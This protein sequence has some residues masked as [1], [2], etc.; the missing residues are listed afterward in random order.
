MEMNK[1]TGAG[2]ALLWDES[3]LWGLMAAGALRSAGIRFDLL[4]AG[5][6]RAGALADYGAIYVPGGWAGQKLACLGEAGTAGIRSFV[7]NGGTYIGICGGAGLATAD[8]L[9][10]LE[11]RRKPAGERVPSFSG[12]IRLSTNPHDIWNGIAQPVFTAAWPSQLQIENREIKILAQ[13]GKARPQAFSSDINVADGAAIGWPILEGLYGMLLDPARLEGEPAVVE[14]NF[15]RGRVLLSLVHFDYPHDTNGAAVLR[16]IFNNPSPSPAAGTI[17]KKNGPGP[18]PP[19]KIPVT[20]AEIQSDID[21]IIET[22]ERNFL[23]YRRNHMLLQ[24]KRGVRGLEYSAL[25]ALAGEVSAIIGNPGVPLP[26]LFFLDESLEEIRERLRPFA[27]KAVRLLAKERLYL[28]TRLL[29]PLHCED[30]EITGLRREL[31]GTAMSHG[32]EFRPLIDAL[33]RL[34]YTLMKARANQRVGRNDC[35]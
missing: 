1:N 25:S 23:W 17:Q 26:E 9:G 3:F 14:G 34:L 30:E 19:G 28:S 18:R 31:F 2:C 32:G 6:I 33:D 7:E 10:L 35:C 11:I 16:N 29:S 5:D 27:E 12:P 8:G 22:G 24:W 21:W 15:G 4:R 20:M 13:Y